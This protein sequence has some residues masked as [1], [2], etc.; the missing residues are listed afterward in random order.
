MTKFQHTLLALPFAAL[1]NGCV[2][3][4]GDGEYSDHHSGWQHTERENREQIAQFN[5]NMSETTV[6]ERLGKPDFS[7]AYRE[8]SADVRVLFY[9]TQRQNSDGITTKD[10]CTPLVFKNGLLV[11]WGD[12]VYAD[13]SRA[14]PL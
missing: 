3:A 12:K 10:E 5:L 7:E 4:I 6:R 2:V 1:L 9:R 11:G 13:A 14:N 8:G